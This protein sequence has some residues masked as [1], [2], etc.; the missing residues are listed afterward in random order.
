MNATIANNGGESTLT[1]ELDFNQILDDNFAEVC[2][3]VE[4]KGFF[5]KEMVK[6]FIENPR[7]IDEII[8]LLMKIDDRKEAAKRLCER[9]GISGITAHRILGMSLSDLTGLTANNLKSELENYMACV[10]NIR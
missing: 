3:A 10:A 1:V 6:L 7:V 5:L 2:K 9:F 4:S 8:Q